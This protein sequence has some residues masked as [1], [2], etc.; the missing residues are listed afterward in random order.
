M[1][2]AV[3]AQVLTALAQGAGGEAGKRAWAAL[4]AL[5]ARFC[6]HRGNVMSAVREAGPGDG[7]NPGR[8]GG[9]AALLD[10]QAR[11]DPGFAAEL[12]HWLTRARDLP[13]T[14]EGAVNTISGKVSGQVVQARDVSGGIS[15]GGT[16]GSPA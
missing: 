4:E 14:A 11:V 2:I 10:E 8:L 7:T 5:A 12:D 16:P 3:L 15:F 6:G 9:L 13:A 1:D